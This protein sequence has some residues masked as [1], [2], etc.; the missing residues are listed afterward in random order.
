MRSARRVDGVAVDGVAS[1][2]RQ[3]DLRQRRAACWKSISSTI[4]G[5]LY[6]RIVDVEFVGWIRGEE[7]FDGIEP[8]DRPHGPRLAGSPADRLRG[9]APLSM[10]G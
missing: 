4:A 1:F 2:G 5:D 3:A 6:G 10:I 9:T 7:K 8:L